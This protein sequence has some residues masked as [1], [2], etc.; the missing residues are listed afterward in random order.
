MHGQDTTDIPDTRL[1]N[2]CSSAMDTLK[3]IP[4]VKYFHAPTLCISAVKLGTRYCMQLCGSKV[5][6]YT[7]NK[8]DTCRKG[9]MPHL[10]AVR[11]ILGHLQ[12]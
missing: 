5:M 10:I 7:C 9:L 2:N 1:K 12:Q 11:T 3:N 6:H 8:T 4:T